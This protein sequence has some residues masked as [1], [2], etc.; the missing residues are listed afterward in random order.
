MDP[1]EM[2]ENLSNLKDKVLKSKSLDYENQLETLKTTFDEVY[3]AATANKVS[4]NY[5]TVAC[6]TL[7]IWFTRT[8]KFL[9]K[10]ANARMEFHDLLT[11]EKSTF[12][13]HYVIDFW[14]DS[15]AALGNALKELFTKM[16]SYLT[17]TLDTEISNLL[18]KKW[19]QTS[20]DL[21]YTMR[22][23]YF[24]I[25]HL[26]KYVQPVDFVLKNKP[27]FI[28]DCLANIWSRALGSIVGKTVYLILKYN[29]NKKDEDYWLSLWENQIIN[30]LYNVNLR[31]GIESYILPNLFQISKTATIKFL[32]SV[33]KHNNIPILLST[34]KVAQDNAILIEPFVEID[35]TTHKP[36]IDIE[37]ISALLKVQTASYRIG[38]FQLLVSSPKLAKSIP[39][40]VYSIISNSF[41]MIFI[42]GDL[43]TRNEMFS[44]FK[45]F[46]TRIKD[47]TYALQRDATSLTQKNFTKFKLEI[48]QKLQSIKE[49]KEFL[50]KL[51]DYIKFNLRPG[52]SYLKKE[53]SYK[54]LLVLIKS[55]LDSRISTKYLEK[56]KTVNF[57]FS[58]EI[59]DSLLFRLIIDNIM[60]NFDDIRSYSTEIISM[61]PLT[62]DSYIN[63]G[64]LE[65]RAL[66]MLSDIKGKEVDSGARFFKFTFCYYQNI[67]DLEECGRIIC[68]LLEKIDISLLKLKGDIAVACTSYSIQGYFAA[69]KFIFE[70]MD[71]K[72]CSSILISKDVLNRL[73]KQSLCT[74]EQVKNVLQHESPEGIVLEEFESK[75]TIEYEEKY[76][77]GTQVLSSYAWRSIKESSNMID[78]LLKFNSP[79][80]D[81][82]VMEIG[83][84]LLEQLATIRHRGA[85][86]SVYPTF[87]SC[88]RLCI[89][90]KELETIPSQW[91]EENLKLI[92]TK[93]KFITRR[94]AGIPFLLT[95]ILSSDKKFIKPTFYRLCEVANLPVAE[96]DADMDNVNLPQVNAYNCIKALFIDST[97]SEESILYVDDAF[98][99]TLNSF[100][101][102]FWAIRNCAVMLFTAL[103]N[104]LFSSKKVKTNY[105]PSYPARLFFEKFESIQGLFYNTLKESI[106][107]GLENQSEIEKVFPILTVMSRLEPTPGYTG[108]N[109][110]IPLIINILENKIWK[111]REIAA[112][113]LPSMIADD[114]SF[115]NIVV[116][117]L[118]NVKSNN[119]N[120]NKIH[121]S[122]LAVREIFSKF[123]SLLAEETDEAIEKLLF[124]K[125][126]Y[127]RSRLLSMGATVLNDIDCYPIKMTYLQI[128]SKMQVSENNVINEIFVWLKNN[129]HPD[130]ILDGSKQLALKE[131]S[132]IL[133]TNFGDDKELIKECIFSSH[134]ELPLSCIKH[135]NSCEISNDEISRLLIVYLWELVETEN[136]WNYIKSQA[137]KLLKELIINVDKF[138]FNKNLLSHTAK[139]MNLLKSETNEDIKLSVT[140]AL[141]SYIATIAI[142]N[143]KLCRSLFY[144]YINNIQSMLSD[145]VEFVTR[146][147]GVKSLLAFNEVYYS[148]GDDEKIKLTIIILIFEFLTDDDESV[149]NL[150][151]QHLSQ[152]VLNKGTE[153]FIPTEVEKMMV[154]YFCE[155]KDIELLDMFI[156]DKSF[157][158]YD[159]E[160]KFVDTITG[161]M[162]LFSSEKSNLE[163]NPVDKVKELIEI[164][165]KT[166]LHNDMKSLTHLNTSLIRNIQDIIIYLQIHKESDGCFGLFSSE[167]VFDFVYCNLLLCNCLVKYNVVEFLDNRLHDILVDDSMYCHPLIL[168]LIK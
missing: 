83:P 80:T 103:Q 58:I 124:D 132:E 162:L 63:M 55:G 142:S 148:N 75:Y 1:L 36:L 109:K 32:K 118:D 87:V 128:L 73:I 10:N 121:G 113:S 59:Y 64:L 29:Y 155:I 102:P 8:L 127:I 154:K 51:L 81:N 115:Q 28:S 136:V 34:L 125:E 82:N 45:K 23:F 3:I 44:Y 54:L 13:F 135:Y 163:R 47:S 105:L 61:A 24:M 164:I 76:G 46:I 149:C 65:T 27:N 104:R 122:L 97:L 126:S 67:G 79:I 140:E 37:D 129:N 144:E 110:F 2:D 15:G 157:N 158:F 156:S 66:T 161:D 9:N 5:R 53:M 62:L 89:K 139:L 95:A 130:N 114:I 77:K 151:S 71:F 168:E 147:A 38:A 78:V 91:L 26:H 33:I 117:L 69:F 84:I 72:K 111:V 41:D 16:L 12:I 93:S 49:S 35:Q 11:E 167:R 152:Y 123:L 133:F 90:R 106:S 42:D 14:N 134:Y 70:I 101:S 138:S 166:D 153:K 141:G 17:L 6:D 85:F 40:I 7:S 88:C 52:S 21:S 146:N 39:S 22:A 94:S 108:L 57:V 143:P 30:G 159:A 165:D 74:W 100:S 150:A 4:L 145:D 96:L 160:T 43:E 112:R 31:K 56:S 68:L 18:F 120:Y 92:Q 107:T 48:N 20:L 98:S 86:S 60:D 131:A 99:L 119:K 25:E 19:L 116:E 50:I 137:L